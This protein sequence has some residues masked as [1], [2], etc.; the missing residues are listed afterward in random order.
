MQDRARALLE[1]LEEGETVSTIAYGDSITDGWGTDGTHVYHRMFLDC[2]RYRFPECIFEHRVQGNPGW[3]TADALR[4]FDR[5]VARFEP[6][7][8]VVQF[9]GNDRG[10]GRPLGRFRAGLTELLSRAVSETDALVIACLPPI[11]EEIGDNE[12]S[13]TARE[14][15]AEAGVPAAWFHQA[16]EEGPHDFRGS[17]PYGSHPGSFTHVIMAREVLRAFDS[18]VGA[19]PLVRCELVRGADVSAEAG[20]DVQATV[21]SPPDETVE[22]AMRMEFGQQA[23]DLQGTVAAGEPVTVSE[24]FR[25]PERSPAGRAWSIPI[26]IRVRSGNAGAFDAGWL[27]IAP[28]ISVSAD[29]SNQWHVLDAPALVL[30]KH[31]WQGPDDLSARFRVSTSDQH[32]LVEVEVT[33]DQVTVAGLT[34]PSRGDSVEVYLDLRSRK[35]EG[36][37][38]YSENVLAL[39]VLPPEETGGR[40]R[41]RNMHDL[42]D[43]LRSLEVTGALGTEG[44]QVVAQIPLSAIQA[45]RGED[46]GGIGLDVGVNDADGGTRKSQMM[47]I[48]TADNYLNPAY[49]AGVYPRKLPIGAT[50][51]ALR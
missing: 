40:V 9:G 48:G 24:H 12:W 23:R 3:T 18:A 49:L 39:Q 28:A 2:L 37:P 41:W 15:A 36:R 30:G 19:R 5:Q 29:T 21:M 17:F 38:V 13:L 51:R 42:P 32:L 44:Y 31:L 50:R 26:S 10:W 16:I 25:V 43:D 34:D 8:L 7:L 1:R 35:G 6:D 46:W 4:G 14:V 45:R 22:W 47:W 20:Y 27:T 33:D 11:A